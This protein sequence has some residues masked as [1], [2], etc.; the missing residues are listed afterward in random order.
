MVACDA[1]KAY[2]VK[3][4]ENV[5]NTEISNIATLCLTDEQKTEYRNAIDEVKGEFDDVVET[6]A[7]TT[8]YVE[9]VRKAHDAYF[10]TDANVKNSDPYQEALNTSA[11]SKAN[12][13]AYDKIMALHDAAQKDYADI[14]SDINQLIIGHMPGQVT[15]D[16]ESLKKNIEIVEE[17][18]DYWKEKGLCT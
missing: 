5:Y 6:Y 3:D 17:N 18:V 7:Q 13:E 15:A 8:D 2:L 4:I 11:L 14:I 9:A 16:L 1:E 10:G 12:L